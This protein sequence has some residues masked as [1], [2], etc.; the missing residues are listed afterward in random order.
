MWWSATLGQHWK[1]SQLNTFV[2]YSYFSMDYNIYIYIYTNHSA[3]RSLD[4]WECFWKNIWTLIHWFIG[5]PNMQ[6]GHVKVI[7]IVA[8][9]IRRGLFTIGCGIMKWQDW[10]S[11]Y[12]TVRGGTEPASS[13]KFGWICCIFYED[14]HAFRNQKFWCVG[15]LYLEI[16]LKIKNPY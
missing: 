9:K 11:I 6:L 14:Y 8:P 7:G 10:P 4:L 3:P 2:F 12:W 13:Q 15:L 16:F 1:T 5:W